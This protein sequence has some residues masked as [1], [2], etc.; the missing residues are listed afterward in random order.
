MLYQMWTIATP[1]EKEAKTNFICKIPELASMIISQNEQFVIKDPYCDLSN[2]L[3]DQH[4]VPI[5][6]AQIANCFEGQN[7]NHPEIHIGRKQIALMGDYQ[8]LTIKFDGGLV[9]S[10]ICSI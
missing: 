10:I 7:A 6:L 8:N 2:L 4:G 1:L 9:E 5:S 3:I